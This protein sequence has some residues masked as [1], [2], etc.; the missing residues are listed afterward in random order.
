MVYLCNSKLGLTS[1]LQKMSSNPSK[2]IIFD[3]FQFDNRYVFQYIHIELYNYIVTKC[4]HVFISYD[5]TMKELLLLTL[6]S[7]L[8]L[9]TRGDRF[10]ALK[11]GEANKDYILYQP[12]MQPFETGFTVCA[13]IRKLKS[14]NIPTWFSYAVSGQPHEIEITDMG[15]R[16]TIF[17]YHSDL[18]SLYTVTHGTWFHNCLGW[19]ATSQTR[20]VYINGALVDSKA[21][22]VGRTLRQGGYLVLGNEQQSG[23]GKGMDDTNKFS[24]E[25]FKLNMFSKK[26]SDHDIKEMATDMCSV[27]E[28]THGEVRGIKW[29]DVLLQTRTGKV[30]LT[31]IDSLCIENMRDTLRKREAKL[32]STLAQLE[33]KG[34]QLN[35][36]IRELNQTKEEKETFRAK[37]ENKTQQLKATEI[38]KQKTIKEL[39]KE[40]NTTTA[41]LNKNQVELEHIKYL[42]GESANATMDCLLNTTF[43]NH[44]DLLHSEKFFEIV[45]TGNKLEVLRK[46]MQNLGIFIYIINSLFISNLIISLIYI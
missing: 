12:N 3:T 25:M 43:T 41:T 32:N 18:Q 2:Y 4:N 7:L 22:P 28:E 5:T 23:P 8:L 20:N 40:L 15:D 21:T 24:G 14:S 30:T 36:T 17:G 42:L 11:F 46:S 10:N 26:L 1:I 31:G 27:V 6:L 34:Q 33:N 19:D 39:N 9:P 13:W 38:Q 16:T 35:E 37:L 45:I 44:L 29:E